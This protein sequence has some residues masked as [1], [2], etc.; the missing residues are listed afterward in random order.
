M[1]F[2]DS[3]KNV[4]KGREKGAYIPPEYRRGAIATKQEEKDYKK[5]EKKTANM[6]HP[7]KMEFLRAQRRK[8][9]KDFKEMMAK[10]P[11]NTLTKRECPVCLQ[12]MMVG[13]GQL[14]FCHAHC[15]PAYKRAR[16]RAIAMQ[17]R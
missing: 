3:V 4:F 6:S 8:A 17:N 2:I 10:K 9:D 13:V 11:A 16:R 5:N 1:S 12:P 15:K 7:Q 14:Q